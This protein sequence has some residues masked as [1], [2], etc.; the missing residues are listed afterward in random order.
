MYNCPKCSWEPPDYPFYYCRNGK[1]IDCTRM[2]PD[3]STLIEDIDFSDDLSS[4]FS[5]IMEVP[6][7][8]EF[9]LEGKSPSKY[10]KCYPIVEKYHSS[11]YAS[12]E[13]GITGHEWI[14]T[15]RCP[16]CKKEF[17][18]DNSDF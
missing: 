16:I 14:E 9:H 3:R 1:A 17:S 8:N 7:P 12:Y 10:F 11:P 4:I 13:F 6:S 18:F 2:V 5:K 15:H